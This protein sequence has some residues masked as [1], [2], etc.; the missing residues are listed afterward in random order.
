MSAMS[1]MGSSMSIEHM[2]GASAA[3][4]MFHLAAKYVKSTDM[5]PIF[6]AYAGDLMAL[7]MSQ[8][9]A[10]YAAVCTINASIHTN[11]GFFYKW[12]GGSA[13]GDFMGIW[14]LIAVLSFLLWSLVISVVGYVEAGLIW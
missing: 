13:I 9:A 2:V 14:E 11:S 7:M 8:L 4:L 3:F 10:A 5:T 6:Y 1:A 12:R